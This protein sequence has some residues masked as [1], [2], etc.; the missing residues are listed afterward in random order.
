MR[1]LRDGP[2]T[3]TQLNAA[4]N[5]NIPQER[6]LPILQQLES[7]QRIVITKTKGKGRPTTFISLATYFAGNAVNE[8]NELHETSEKSP[9]LFSLNSSI[10]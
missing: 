7:Q 3:A 5:R 4:L 10:S 6:I 2:I 9:D 1:A 8:K